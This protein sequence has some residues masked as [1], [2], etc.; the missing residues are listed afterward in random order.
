MNTLLFSVDECHVSMDGG[1]RFCIEPTD[2]SVMYDVHKVSGRRIVMIDFASVKR[3]EWK[4]GEARWIAARLDAPLLMK[5]EQ[6]L[7]EEV[8][9]EEETDT[10]EL[11][12]EYRRRA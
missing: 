7:Q 5:L 8:D 9:Y 1:Y 2:Y 11:I 3:Q 4:D 6:Q 12:A 10:A